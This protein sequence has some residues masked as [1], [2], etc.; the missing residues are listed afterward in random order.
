MKKRGGEKI[1]KGRKRFGKRERKSWKEEIQREK[2]RKTKKNK[3][4][5][6]KLLIIIT[7]N[8]FIRGNFNLR[9]TQDVNNGI[10]NLV[11]FITLP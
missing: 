1:L 11:N 9:F 5:T 8:M 7:R 4:T 10:D 6:R 3:I 2:K